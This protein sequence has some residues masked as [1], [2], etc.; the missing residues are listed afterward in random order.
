MSLERDLNTRICRALRTFD[1]RRV[2]NSVGPGTPDINC[3]FGWIESKRIKSFPRDRTA[4]VPVGHYRPAQRAW[5][6]ARTDLGGV[7][8]VAIQVGDEVFI[9][10]A[11]DAAL[12]L[13]VHWTQ[14]DFRQFALYQAITWWG[15][16]VLVWF[17]RRHPQ[18][19]ATP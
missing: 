17:D 10:N 2:E 18:Q 15:A 13:G 5:H 4:V 12:G 8:Y 14:A 11:R 1:A 19:G 3:T 16:E 7:V 6:I 9:F